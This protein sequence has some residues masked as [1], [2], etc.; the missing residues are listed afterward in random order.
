MR[1]DIYVYAGWLDDPD[2][3]PLIGIF[4]ADREYSSVSFE[5]DEQWIAGQGIQIDPALP[6]FQGRQFLYMERNETP[7]FLAD[8]SPDRWGRG[9]LLRNEQRLAREENR[10]VRSLSPEDFLLGISDHGR[11]GGLRFSAEP[12]GP[13]LASGREIPKMTDLRRLEHAAAAYEDPKQ[14][15]NDQWLRDLFE[16][17]SSLGGAR[18]K[19]NVQ[20]QEGALWI[21]KFPSRF[22]RHDV[23]AWEQTA[24]ELAKACGISVPDSR[25]LH[26]TEG[27]STYLSRRFDRA[28]GRRLHFMSAMTALSENDRSA[29]E[30][31]KGFL[32]IAEMITCMSSAPK[33]D[34]RE[35]YLRTA[36]SICISNTDCH[37]RNHAFLLTEKGWRLSP[38]YDMN[39]NPEKGQMAIPVN[40]RDAA[41]DLS[42]LME[43]AAFYQLTENE[44]GS[45]IRQVQHIVSQKWRHEAGKAG[46]SAAEQAYMQPAF[47]EAEMGQKNRF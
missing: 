15:A 14:L 7:G 26:L 9:L 13:F 38:A 32:D 24:H 39:P 46:I 21:A 27:R 19:A 22:D 29:S 4:H 18:P 45:L 31:G 30:S 20:D 44:A 3:P 25:L 10:R 17:G 8:A 40:D 42:L 23:G 11:Q 2:R 1:T 6:I 16:P 36:F 12:G 28:G 5:Y 35:M 47:R 33:E 41:I 43:T 37:F 34:L